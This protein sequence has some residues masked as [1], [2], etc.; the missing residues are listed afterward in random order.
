M[1]PGQN[2]SVNLSSVTP[3][4]SYTIRRMSV[5]NVCEATEVIKD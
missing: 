1:Y 5:R 4:A 3:F 2:L